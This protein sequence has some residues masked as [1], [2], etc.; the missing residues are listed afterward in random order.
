VGVLLSIKDVGVLLSIKDVGVLLSI[1]DVGVLLSIKDAGV[2]L[3]SAASYTFR[4][5]LAFLVVFS[6]FWGPV[7]NLCIL[8][9]GDVRT[10]AFLLSFGL[11]ESHR[12][13]YINFS[14]KVNGEKSYFVL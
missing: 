1:K 14:I 3:L 9:C 4:N 2:L 6:D 10:E 12:F 7:F 11:T 8:M 5:F 13:L